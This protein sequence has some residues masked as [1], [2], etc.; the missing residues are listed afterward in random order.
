MYTYTYKVYTYN[1]Y[2][3]KISPILS[4]YLS[5]SMT[6]RKRYI[7][8][9]LVLCASREYIMFHVVI[10][11]ELLK[12]GG[13]FSSILIVPPPESLRRGTILKGGAVT[14]MED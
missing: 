9:R 13:T 11:P 3:E 14:P 1:I 4:L 2:K 6:F 5:S 10:L 8:L 12:G 7:K